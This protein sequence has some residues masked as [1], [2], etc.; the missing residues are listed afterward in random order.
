MTLTSALNSAKSVFSNTGEQ[1]SVISKNIANASNESYVK[2]YTNIATS[3]NG[4]TVVSIGRAENAILQNQMFLSSSESAGQ[5]TLL[6]GLKQL[7]SILGG[8]DYEL[9]PATYLSKFFDSLQQFAAKPGDTSLAQT[10]ISTAQDIVNSLNRSSASIQTIREQADSDISSSVTKLNALLDNLKDVNDRVISL[11]STG[12]DPNDALDQRDKIISDI[13]QYV[14]VTIQKR[15][16][17][18]VALY[19]ADGTTLFE[20]I[21]RTVSFAPQ[22]TYDAGTVGNA[23]Y[24]D[25]TAVQLG[26]GGDTSARG[27]IA[28]NLQLRDEIAP[29]FQSQFDEIARGLITVFDDSGVPGLFAWSE[30]TTPVPLPGTALP[31]GQIQPGLASLISINTDYLSSAGG[32]PMRLRDGNSVDQNPDDN[33]GFSDLLFSYLDAMQGNM[34]FDPLAQVNEST[35]LLNFS[36]GSIG[37]LEDYRSSATSASEN[38]TAMLL[39]SSDAY[40]S[41]TGVSL[42]EELTLLLDIEQSYKAASKLLTT[43]DEM[44]KSLIAAAG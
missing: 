19:T 27:S 40:S 34:D 23:V 7:K 9:S 41:K 32:D 3:G 13:S 43:I 16:N 22:S 38:K 33:A 28:A 36:T 15:P 14:G 5:E 11:T 29:V 30:G 10:A 31:D 39:R 6:D 37:W 25:G 35:S 18:D 8:N 24:I 20:T 42:D 4:A 17:N 12:G 2:R 1:S 44:L 21:P 26:V